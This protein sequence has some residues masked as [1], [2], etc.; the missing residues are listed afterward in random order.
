[1]A[2]VRT[3][4]LGCAAIV[5]GGA[6]AADLPA[7]TA[8]PVEYVRVCSTYG[9][10]FFYVPGTDTCL[11]VSGRVRAEY[12]YVEPV[13]RTQDSI[14]FRA[15]GRINLDART[16]TAY[17]LL[18]TYIR[19][20]MTRNT[21]AYGFSSTTPN[22]AQAYVQFGG[23]TA[24][25]AVSF[26]TDPNLPAPN[27]GDLR[28]DDPANAEVN[29]LAYTF[30]F[31][32]GFSA[33]LSLED[34]TQRQVNNEL[35]FPLFGVGSTSP[36]FAPIASTYAGERIPDV[37]ANV[38]Y[39]GTWGGVQLS[40]ALH[41]IRDASAGFTTVDGVSVPVINPVTGL[42]NP[43]FADTEYGFAVSALGYAN[44]PALGEGDAVWFSATYT[45]GAIGYLNAGQASP[46]SNGS[47]SAGSLAMAITDAFVDPF[48]GDFKNNKAY[49]IAG[50]L[51]HNWTSTIQTNVF[52][53]W[54]R[55]DAPGI[56][57][58]TIPATPLTIAEGTAGTT[59]GLVD[60]DE[61][62]IGA[63]VIWTPVK[64]FLIGVEALYIRVDPRERVAVP[65]TT[66]SGDA[67]GLFR[68]TGSE[69][70]WEGRLRVQRDF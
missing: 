28:F 39:T 35:D 36:V 23:L 47:I 56:A 62:R 60:F 25:R 66:A 34:G 32:N 19:M 67:T 51:N 22:I 4:L 49:S 52:G 58:Y 61:Y 55:F 57:Q 3:L 45:D 16:P 7:K 42:P 50:G 11:R 9:T 33:T 40:G 12:L 30:S 18:R 37:V 46:I 63:N 20:E 64:D 43:A 31:G 70:T 1:M 53:S 38:R 6:Q 17:G 54:M 59:T 21:G 26:F 69:S 15:R 48:T 2:S 44:V 14:G 41:Q 8:A 29:L 68:A 65:V 13:D 27:F 24:G 10:G 5:T